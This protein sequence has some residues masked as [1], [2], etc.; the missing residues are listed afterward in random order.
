VA[1]ELIGPVLPGQRLLVH[2]GV[3][4]ARLEPVSREGAG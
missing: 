3:A 4:I 1:T 2:A